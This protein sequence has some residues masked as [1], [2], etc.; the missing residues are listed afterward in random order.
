MMFEGEHSVDVQEELEM[1]VVDGY[2]YNCI[3]I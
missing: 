2:A 1:G 3:H